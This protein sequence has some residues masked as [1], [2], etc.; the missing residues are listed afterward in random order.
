MI[1]NF[2]PFFG[3][4]T[5]P[6]TLR[7]KGQNLSRMTIMRS[8]WGRLIVIFITLG[9]VLILSTQINQI[10]QLA[11]HGCDLLWTPLHVNLDLRF[12]VNIVLPHVDPFVMVWLMILRDMFSSN[13]YYWMWFG[14]GF[15]CT[16]SYV[17]DHLVASSVWA[18]WWALVSS[19]SV[20][21][22]LIGLL[23]TFLLN[24][25]IQITTEVFL[26]A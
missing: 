1:F 8:N 23:K 13:Y 25:I 24:S 3:H 7:V 10:L 26:P 16:Y 6:K 5:D 15:Y 9:I 11:S 17:V 19:L 21:T 18:R 2:H 20:G 14:I 4:A 12:Y 22:W